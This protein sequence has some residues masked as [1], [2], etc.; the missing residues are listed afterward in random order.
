MFTP[1]SLALS[2]RY[3]TIVHNVWRYYGAMN[4]VKARYQQ[5][6]QYMETLEGRKN[7][8]G[9][10]EI[11]CQF[12]D[13]NPITK[14]PCHITAALS[15]IHDV[16]RMGDLAAALEGLEGGIAEGEA[17]GEEGGLPP[18]AGDT[19]MWKVKNAALTAEFHTPCTT[20]IAAAATT[21]GSTGGIGGSTPSTLPSTPPSIPP[22]S[23]PR[24]PPR[25]PSSPPSSPPTC[26]GNYGGFWDEVG[27][28]YGSGS[29]MSVAAALWV[30]GMPE[31]RQ[32]PLL[33][34][35]ATQVLVYS[36]D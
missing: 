27:S 16:R 2:P 20:T 18:W 15:Y 7:S 9:L 29:Q 34:A 11:F 22:R 21:T 24:S 28:T 12:G 17:G 36:H 26:A 31:G 13:W 14:T 5:L 32:A 4:V 1:P 10:G 35:L 23:P 6:K 8:T 3:V 30:G 25:P 33:D 19:A